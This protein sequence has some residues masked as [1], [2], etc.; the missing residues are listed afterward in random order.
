MIKHKNMIELAIWIAL[1]AHSHQEDKNGQPYIL[2]PLR[3]MSHF[4]GGASEVHRIVAVLHDVV[5]DTNVELDELTDFGE[6][7]VSAMDAITHRAGESYVAYIKRLA[8]NKIARSVKLVDLDDNMN[9]IRLA[10]LSITQAKSLASKHAWAV[11]Y[12]MNWEDE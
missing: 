7:V 11:H 8:P 6:E 5:E 12:L 2:H 9:P 3:V 1:N 10:G 4:I